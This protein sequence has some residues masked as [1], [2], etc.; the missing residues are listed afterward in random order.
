M[1]EAFLWHNLAVSDN[2]YLKRIMTD[3]KAFPQH[4]T[5]GLGSSE[6]LG[7]WSSITKST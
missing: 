2:P 7:L 1:W 6:N 4:L 3:A 5:R